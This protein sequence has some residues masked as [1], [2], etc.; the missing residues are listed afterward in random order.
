MPYNVV[1]RVFSVLLSCLPLA[2]GATSPAAADIGVTRHANVV[3]PAKPISSRTQLDAYLRDTPESRSPLNWLTPAARKRFLDGMVFGEHG[4]GG[5]YLGD[6]A[7]ELTREQSY[8]LLRLFGAQSYA[9]DLDGRSA[10]RPT[11]AS[12][13]ASTL[14]SGYNQLAAT[15][16]QLDHSAD[17]VAQIYAE[18]F[19]AIQSDAQ[20][21]ALGDRDVEFLFRAATLAFQIDHQPAYVDDMRA[22]FSELQRRHLVEG[23]HASD[24]YDVLIIT[25]KTTEARSL[26]VSY[27]M[28]KHGA[29]PTMKIASRVQRGWSSLWIVNTERGKR[30]LVR[31]PFNIHARAQ[32]IVLASTRDQFSEQAARAIEADPR[33][34]D[35][36]RE[37]AQWVAP[38]N[39]LPE[40]D[41]I[42][43]WNEAYTSSRLGV[44]HDD[45][46][47]P[48]VRRIE[49][50]TF[51]FLDHGQVV[52]T[53]VGWPQGGNIEALQRGLR[54]IDLQR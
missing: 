28:I 11:D 15:T 27:P 52:D 31:Y 2:L 7:Y 34:R 37:N 18:R 16:A 30:E 1:A 9:L 39:E 43:T 25:G 48:M 12:G 5:L 29:V 46:E 36:F 50:P 32:I 33:L 44:I 24:L 19:S 8:T 26:Q 49:T 42:K 47:L 38:A 54:M 10:P 4:L 6:L 3:I 23:P 53:V 40:F 41:A 14:E 21:H 13:E 20:R 17:A 45:A 35:V 22:D 51:Y